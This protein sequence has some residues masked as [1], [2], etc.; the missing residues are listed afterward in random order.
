[1]LPF[2]TTANT[3]RD[4]DAIRAALGERRVSYYGLSYGTYLGSVYASLFPHRTDRV[5]LDSSVDPALRDDEDSQSYGEGMEDRF[6][7][8]ARFAVRNARTVGFGNTEAKVRAKYLAVADRL[9][10]KPAKVAGSPVPLNGNLVRLFTFLLAHDDA[11]LPTALGPFWHAAGA[12]AAGSATLKDAAVVAGIIN[13]FAGQA[14][15]PG[16]PDDNFNAVGTA[17]LCND[18]SWPRDVRRYARNVAWDRIEHPL[19]AGMPYN[20]WPCTFWKTQPIEP[21]V[22]VTDA[23]PRNVL[24]VQN[25]RDEATPLSAA[26]GMRRALGGRSVLV[27]VDAG[28]HGVLIATK[29]NACALSTLGAFLAD[30]KLPRR[31]VTCARS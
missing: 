9:Q 26:Q 28:G 30:G 31:D 16:V 6:P 10:R 20:V 2:I 17:V 24:I 29:Q 4:M 11:N 21:P 12:Y 19:T 13:Q 25:Q 15:T 3:A 18:S 5:V 8:L 22:R 23:G 27:D 14:A 1:M 7:D